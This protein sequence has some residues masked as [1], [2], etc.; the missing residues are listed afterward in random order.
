MHRHAQTEKII[1]GLPFVAFDVGGD[2][3]APGCCID[4]VVMV[5]EDPGI[6]HIGYDGR[7]VPA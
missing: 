7:S 1:G 3:E 6:C 5:P 4:V 2:S